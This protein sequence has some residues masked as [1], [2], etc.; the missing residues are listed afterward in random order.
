[1]LF[2]MK[3]IKLICLLLCAVS[4]LHAQQ[5]IKIVLVGTMH[6][7][8]SQSDMYKNDKVDLKNA[9]RQAQIKEV[10]SKFV[11]FNPDQVCVEYTTGRQKFVDSLYSAFLKG[12]YKLSDNEIDQLGMNTAKQLNLKQL[13]AV[14]RF[15]E[16][17]SDTVMKYAEKNNLMIHAQQMDVFAKAFIQIFFNLPQY[18]KS[19]ANQFGYLFEVFCKN[20]ERR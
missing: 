14:N 15:G 11:A 19:F 3:I 9:E 2:S 12:T 1:M 16:F 8:Q 7:E 13:T 10:V 4:S 6:F 17:D 18:S 20:R 5:K